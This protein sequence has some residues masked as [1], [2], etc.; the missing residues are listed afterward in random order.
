MAIESTLETARRRVAEKLASRQ[1][2][3]VK[4]VSPEMLMLIL[5]ATLLV[6]ERCL[7]N[8]RLEEVADRIHDPGLLEELAVRQGVRQVMRETYGPF[9]FYRHGGAELAQALLET[10]REAS[11]QERHE[12]LRQVGKRLA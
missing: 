10:G 3:D 6:I 8:H 1:G 11:E 4:A 9:G 2:R 5:E 7:A 12:F